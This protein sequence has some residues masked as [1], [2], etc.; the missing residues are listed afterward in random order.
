M[1]ESVIIIKSR[2]RE[3][4]I[5]IVL[6]SKDLF[7]DKYNYCATQLHEI[8]HVTGSNERLNHNILSNSK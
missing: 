4:L 1:K 2:M 7:I 8:S 6:L 3:K 5:K